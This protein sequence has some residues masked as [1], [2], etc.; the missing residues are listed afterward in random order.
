MNR[1]FAVAVTVGEAVKNLGSTVALSATVA[2]LSMA[3][4]VAVPTATAIEVG[5]I[6]R[7][8]RRATSAGINVMSVTVENRGPISAARCEDLGR[9]SGVLS[10][11]GIVA[12]ESISL[13]TRPHEALEL[14]RATPGAV[15][16]LWPNQRTQASA[17]SV[18]A[19]SIVATLHGLGENS[20]LGYRVA[21]GSEV[22]YA[23]VGATAPA[24]ARG[25][26]LDN[27]IVIA[28]APVGVVTE[29]L[30][31]SMPGARDDVLLAL[32]GWFPRDAGVV[33]SPFYLPDSSWSSPDERLET[34]MSQQ[35]PLLG[36]VALTAAVLAVWFARRADFAL[37]RHLGMSRRRLL[38]MQ[39]A[40]AVMLV[41]LPASLGLTVSL[42]LLASDPLPLVVYL[43]SLDALRLVTL[44]MLVPLVG[45][46]LL[47]RAT[48]LDALKGR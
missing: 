14:I 45:G 36:A 12:R 44:L 35:F 33:I 32:E 25:E 7:D 13:I 30:V 48:R 29:C 27:T 26:R 6:E 5:S 1:G 10:A 42:F 31:E 16:V 28:S 40:E 41:I 24:S 37:Y 19:G 39:V 9:V 23:I 15:R 46:A 2:V 3:I 43:T 21:R 11:G 17:S 4:G 8:A 22:N 18:I 20:I 34:R 47:L 38:L